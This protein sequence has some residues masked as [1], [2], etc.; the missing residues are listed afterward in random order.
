MRAEKEGQRVRQGRVRGVCAGVKARCQGGIAA[1]WT[2][3]ARVRSERPGRR[4][5][6]DP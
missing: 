5:L 1:G 4:E 2:K 6:M 3:S